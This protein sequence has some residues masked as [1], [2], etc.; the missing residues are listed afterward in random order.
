MLSPPKEEDVG[1][2]HVLISWQAW[3]EVEQF[4][5]GFGQVRAYKIYTRIAGTG[6]DWVN[7]GYVVSADSNGNTFSFNLTSL[8]PSTEMEIGITAIDSCSGEEGGQGPSLSITTLG[9]VN[10]LLP[11]F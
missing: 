3:Q 9:R 7:V 1:S 5:S 8:E 6:A 4:Q 2:T 11:R 10:P